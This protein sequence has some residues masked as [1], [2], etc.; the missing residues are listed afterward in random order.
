MHSYHIQKS[1]EASWSSAKTLVVSYIGMETQ[2]VAI[3]PEMKVLL[4]P[5][6]EVLDEVVVVAYGTQKRASITGAVSAVNAE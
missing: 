4:R 5:N 2:K 3:K 6:A 1:G